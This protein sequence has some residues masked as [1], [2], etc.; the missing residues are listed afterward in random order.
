[1]GEQRKEHRGGHAAERN[2]HLTDPERPAAPVHR[3]GAEERPESGDRDDRRADAGDE[4]RHEQHRRRRRE[5]RGDEPGRP[6]TVP[7]ERSGR[8]EP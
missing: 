7:S 8:R 2:R 6:S 4:Q 1:M 5:R 3:V